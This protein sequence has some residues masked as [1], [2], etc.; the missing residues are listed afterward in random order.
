MYSGVPVTSIAS[1][2][3]TVTTILSPATSVVVL[4]SPELF[5]ALI[6]TLLT[7]GAIAST[8]NVLLLAAGVVD[9]VT[10]LSSK[11]LRVLPLENFNAEVPAVTLPAVA[12]SPL[13]TV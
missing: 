6:V 8:A 4:S 10:S 11:S 3:T 2:M 5:V 9:D 13:V 12:V 7:V 1:S